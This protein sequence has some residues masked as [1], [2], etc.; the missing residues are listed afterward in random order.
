MG[1]KK[2]VRYTEEFKQEVLAAYQ[3]RT[4]NQAE[5]CAQYGISNQTISN[6]LAGRTR[7]TQRRKKS[8]PVAPEQRKQA[9]EA[10]LKSNVPAKEFSNLWGLGTPKTLLKWVKTV[11][12]KG[13]EG[14]SKE[15]YGKGRKRGRKGLPRVVKAKIEETR[16]EKPHF[17]LKSIRDYMMRYKGLKVSTGTIRSTLREANLPRQAKPKTRR[18]KSSEQVRRFERARPM[19]LWQSDITMLNLTRSGIKL[20]LTVFMD[21]CSRYIVG[22][23]LGMKQTGDFV[24]EALLSGI[25]RFGK[26]EEVLTDQGRQYF[27]WRG[28]SEFQRLLN[29]EGIQHVVARSHHPQTV[30]K[31]ERFWETVKSEF[32]DVAKP[33]EL[34]DARNRIAHYIAHYNHTRLHQGL[35]GV[36]PADRFFGLESEVR[37]AIEKTLSDNELRISVGE[38]PRS[39]VFLV[40]QIGE[41]SVSLHGEDGRIIFQ[42]PDGTIEKIEVN[43]LGKPQ[44]EEE[45]KN[46]TNRTATAENEKTENRNEKETWIQDSTASDLG[47]RV[48]GSSDGGTTTNRA[49]DG[50]AFNGVL[51]GT[52]HQGEPI[53]GIKNAAATHLADLK[54]SDLG[55]DSGITHSTEDT[56][57][58]E[59]NTI[60]PG[61][62]SEGS[63]E[64]D[65]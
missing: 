58:N 12:E 16:I 38:A 62:R 64:E 4:C 22:W 9:V 50:S 61:G 14:L 40:G 31:C 37:K 53:E 17:G 28:K 52:N 25:Q 36:T 44:F 49:S 43:R 3:T 29:K 1:G 54:T 24:M 20:Y 27:S 26:P 32:W 5:F 65:S 47:T 10:Y 30:G 18:R 11:Q 42:K 46:G 51:D 33:Q 48:M 41:Q 21:D 55:Y 19:Q 39:P 15:N 57:A 6:W 34:E 2:Y 23:N 59:E 13:T 56:R 60:E 45:E 8:G 35:D 7:T 63:S